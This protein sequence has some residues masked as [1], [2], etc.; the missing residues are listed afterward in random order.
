M[1]NLTSCATKAA[2]EGDWQKAVDL[3]SKILSENPNDTEALNRRA[4]ALSCL[5]KTREAKKTYQRTL[6]LDPYNHIAQKNLK[7]I[8]AIKGNNS[9][10]VPSPVYCLF[11]EEPGKT[12][13]SNL[14]NPAPEKILSCLSPGTPLDLVIKKHSVSIFKNGDYIG[15]LPD[16][17][18]HRLINLNRL[19]NKYQA[20]MKGVEKNNL[21]VFLQEVKRSKRVGDQPSFPLGKSEGFYPFIHSKDALSIDKEPPEGSLEEEEESDETEEREE[22]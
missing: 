12:K 22:A 4:Y 1:P 13:V 20:H 8:S 9:Q 16:D 15:A 18:A 19:G 21:S 10:T 2:L 11:L 3:N 7:K 17:L 6:L 14:V 5:G